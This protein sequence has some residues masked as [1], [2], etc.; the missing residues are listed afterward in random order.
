[1]SDDDDDDHGSG[2]GGFATRLRRPKVIGDKFPKI[3]SEQGKVLMNSGLYGYAEHF[4]DRRRK[5]KNNVSERLL[6]RKLG[7][8]ARGSFR[9]AN[10]YIAQVCALK[11]LMYVAS[12]HRAVTGY[13]AYHNVCRQSHPLRLAGI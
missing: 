13:G 2:Y 7:L 5:R 9:R 11:V 10:R 3:P 6:W 12:H 4:V 8:D 1:M